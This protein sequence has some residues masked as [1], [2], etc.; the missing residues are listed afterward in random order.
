MDADER[1]CERPLV[2]SAAEEWAA[3]VVVTC[4]VLSGAVVAIAALVGNP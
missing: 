4:L 2:A 3:W 1:R